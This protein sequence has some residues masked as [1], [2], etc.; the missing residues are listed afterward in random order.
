[1]W[2]YLRHKP[3]G[4]RGYNPRTIPQNCLQT[5]LISR[6]KKTSIYW[7]V[8]IGFYWLR[9]KWPQYAHDEALLIRPLS[10]LH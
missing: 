1:M 6:F 3:V 2:K 10:V 4:P 9:V 8:K 5:H 7:I